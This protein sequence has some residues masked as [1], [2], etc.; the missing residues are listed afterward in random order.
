MQMSTTPLFVE[1]LVIGI[2]ACVW[3]A[4]IALSLVGYEWLTAAKSGLS[5]WVPLITI[6]FLAASYSVGI[7]MDR[8]AE[9]FMRLLRPHELILRVKWIKRNVEGA[10]DDPRIPVMVSNNTASAFLEY[11]RSRLRIARATVLNLALISTAA[12]VFVFTRLDSIGCTM[13][14]KAVG[15]IVIIGLLSVIAALVSTAILRATYDVRMRQ[16]KKEMSKKPKPDE[17]DT[18][19]A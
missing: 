4:L 15:T 13:Q 1:V 8:I 7:I 10:A 11:V 9:G 17:P 19:A 6:V 14:W 16:V 2:Q 5:D 12:V 18:G 3:I